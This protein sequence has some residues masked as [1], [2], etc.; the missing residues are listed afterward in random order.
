MQFKIE[1][2]AMF[3]ADDEEPDALDQLAAIEAPC[4]GTRGGAER[5]AVDHHRR[6]QDLV[7]AGQAPVESQTLAQSAPQPEPGLAGET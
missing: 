5:A 4:P 6:G 3:V 2:R 7:A 1:Q